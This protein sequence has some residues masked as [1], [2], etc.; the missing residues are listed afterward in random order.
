LTHSFLGIAILVIAAVLVLV[1]LWNPWRR[2]ESVVLLCVAVAGLVLAV[3]LLWS[4]AGPR[5]PAEWIRWLLVER[6]WILTVS[7][8]A[9]ACLSI[10]MIVLLLTPDRRNLSRRGQSLGGG[11]AQ[12]EA[13]A[14]PD[15]P[16]EPAPLTPDSSPSEPVTACPP[17]WLEYNGA[18]YD[19]PGAAGVPFSLGTAPDCSV[20]LRGAAVCKSHATIALEQIALEQDGYVLYHVLG[21]GAFTTVRVNTEVVTRHILRDRDRIRIGNQ[22]VYFRQQREQGPVARQTSS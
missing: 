21:D 5:V 10:W 20:R 14:A 8:V 13:P 18:R 9:G 2:R 15:K 19:L 7:V 12:G 17:A 11:S 16:P 3:A 22:T 4:Y 6:H 1:G